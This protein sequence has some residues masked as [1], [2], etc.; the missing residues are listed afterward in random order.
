MIMFPS[1]VKY[2]T[3]SCTQNVRTLQWQTAERTQRIC[4]ERTLH[5]YDMNTI[6]ERVTYPAIQS[7]RFVKRLAGHLN[8]CQVIDASGVG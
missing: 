7:V 8:A 2:A 3:T 1:T 4:Q 6:G 5:A